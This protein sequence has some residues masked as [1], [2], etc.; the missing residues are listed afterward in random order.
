M[1]A[2]SYASILFKRWGQK[3]WLGEWNMSHHTSAIEFP[4]G[5]RKLSRAASKRVRA[6]LSCNDVTGG[7]VIDIITLG[8][9]FEELLQ[10]SCTF[11]LFIR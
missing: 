10:I 3:T 4:L 6:S 11:L 2:I 7:E 8:D 1:C 5:V 9:V